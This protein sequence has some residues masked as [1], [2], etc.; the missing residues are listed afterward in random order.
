VNEERML[1]AMTRAQRKQL[2]ELLRSVLHDQEN[3]S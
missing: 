3:R 2:E 1:A